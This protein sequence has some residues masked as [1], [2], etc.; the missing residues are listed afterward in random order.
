MAPLT[1]RCAIGERRARRLRVH[2]RVEL[3]RNGLC[4]RCE[5]VADSVNIFANIDAARP[6]MRQHLLESHHL[7]FRCVP[8]VIEEDVDSAAF[9]SKPLPEMT[10]SA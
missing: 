2:S 6:D 9:R 7:L 8:S 1:L 10:A 3:V 4:V 5:S